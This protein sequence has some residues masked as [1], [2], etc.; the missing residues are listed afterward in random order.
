MSFDQLMAQIGG[1]NLYARA[2]ASGLAR[3]TLPPKI[4]AW[5]KDTEKVEVDKDT[6]IQFLSH[7]FDFCL[8]AAASMTPE[9]LDS[10]VGWAAIV[11]P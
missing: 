8:K 9:R 7:L 2:N 11:G 5:A 6:A 10:V 3:P 1:I 4:A